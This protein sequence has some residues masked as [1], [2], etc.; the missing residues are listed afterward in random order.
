MSDNTSK[1]VNDAI[2]G[3]TQTAKA[4][5]VDPQKLDLMLQLLMEKEARIATEEK[6]KNEAELAKHLQR[7][8]NAAGRFK[9]LLIKQARCTHLKGGKH[10]RNTQA[11][12]YAVY[13][14]TY[15]NSVPAIRCFV[16]RMCWYM[17]D[18]KEFLF[19][20]NKKVPNHTKLGWNEAREMLGTSTNTPSCSEIPFGTR[21]S[22]GMT[23]QDDFDKIVDSY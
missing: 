9:K 16:C 22:A 2:K 15:I 6:N 7:L 21:K 4:V 19:R 5:G 3:D 10:R 1:A 13:Y 12:D 20:N 17:D 23:T 11:K 8:K 18:T 14:F